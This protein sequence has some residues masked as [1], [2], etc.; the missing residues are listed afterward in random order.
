MLNAEKFKY[1]R[2]IAVRHTFSYSEIYPRTMQM[3][4]VQ[5][6]AYFKRLE[7]GIP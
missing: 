7:R 1:T 5:K 2:I 3:F 6:W 4:N